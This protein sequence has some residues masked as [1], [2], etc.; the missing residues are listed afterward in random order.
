MVLHL[1]A[2]ILVRT[3]SVHLLEERLLVLVT[4]LALQ[5][6]LEELGLSR[7]QLLDV[8]LGL[9]L[10]RLDLSSLCDSL[11]GLCGLL[12]LLADL[13]GLDLDLLHDGDLGS[14]GNRLLLNRDIL[15]VKELEEIDAEIVRVVVALADG[16]ELVNCIADE[17][18]D[19]RHFDRPTSTFLLRQIP[20]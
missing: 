12:L 10:G 1:L 11:C 15:V 19:R 13:G 3:Q 5:D 17:L 20:F 2:V 18:L 9:H 8:D 4:V 6:L 16:V 14:L 7:V